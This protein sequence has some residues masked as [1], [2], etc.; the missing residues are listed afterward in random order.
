MCW[1]D[2]IEVSVPW[3]VTN[4]A[5]PSTPSLPWCTSSKKAAEPPKQCMSQ[6]SLQLCD[7]C[8]RQK[9]ATLSPRVQSGWDSC[10]QVCF[11]FPPRKVV[12]AHVFI[13][14]SLGVFV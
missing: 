8:T 6:H 12:Q 3:L 13:A 5:E 7:G 1:G 10:A 4:R 2:M 9:G 14:V 11:F